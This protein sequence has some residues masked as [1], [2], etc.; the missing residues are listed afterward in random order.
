MVRPYIRVVR[1]FMT[2]LSPEE[3]HS[4]VTP[5]RT[6]HGEMKLLTVLLSCLDMKHKIVVDHEIEIMP[7]NSEGSGTRACFPTQGPSE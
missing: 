5:S 3:R 6:K 2:V 4:L 1:Q 7:K